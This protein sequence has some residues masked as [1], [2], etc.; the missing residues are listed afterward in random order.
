[1]NCTERYF[2][3]HSECVKYKNFKRQ[4]ADMKKPDYD[5]IDYK[6]EVVNKARKKR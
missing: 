6:R 1:M 2:N 3:C 5:I 4:I